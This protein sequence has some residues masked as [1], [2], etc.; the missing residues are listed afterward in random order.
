VYMGRAE[1]ERLFTAWTP[2]GDVPIE[3]GGLVVLEGSNNHQRLKATYGQSD[4]DSYCENR[5]G[6]RDGWDNRQGG[7]LA[8]NLVQIQRSIGGRWVTC[9]DYRAGDVVIFS[10]YTVHGGLDN[11][12]NRFRLSSDT[13]YQP[14]SAAAD[15][16]WI[17]P[18]PPA[19]G[20]AG[21]RGRIC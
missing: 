8:K 13:R 18:N 16:R 2:I 20:K 3:L 17:G 5:P 1:T 19:H 14:A 4:V 9:P 21:K 11:Q 6:Q 7:A 10:V 15:E 12:T